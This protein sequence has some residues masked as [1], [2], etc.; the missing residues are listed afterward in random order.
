M[1]TETHDTQTLQRLAAVIR[2]ELKLGPDAALDQSTPLH[3][4]Q[5]DLDSLDVLLLLTSV[6]KE[7]GIKIPNQ[8]LRQNVF[9]T[10]GTLAEF[11]D[12]QRKSNGTTDGHR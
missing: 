9:R 10:L 11:I 6:E 12:E 1:P 3:G 8:A 7:F 5:H 2:R 4:G